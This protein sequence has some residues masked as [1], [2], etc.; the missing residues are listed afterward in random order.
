MYMGPTLHEPRDNTNYGLV[1]FGLV[2]LCYLAAGIFA[3]VQTRRARNGLLVAVGAALLS[4][5]LWYIVFLA[6]TYTMKGTPQQGAVF[7]AEG[8]LDD[9]ARSGSVNFEAWLLEDYPGRRLLSL[10]ARPAHCRCPGRRGR[11]DWQNVDAAP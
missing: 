8:K 3:A 1:E 5:L 7:R 6:I 4:T 10:A 2:F 11:A 9:F